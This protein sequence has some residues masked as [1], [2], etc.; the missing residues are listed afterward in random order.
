MEI[1]FTPS[2]D[3]TV[4]LNALLDILERRHSRNPALRRD[5]VAEHSTRSI[6]LTLANLPLPTYFSQTDP[7]R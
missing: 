2:A 4:A 1:S 6:K 7:R 5:E 3:V